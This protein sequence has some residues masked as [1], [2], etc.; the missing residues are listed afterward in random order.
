MLRQ[1]MFAADGEKVGH[2]AGA[3]SQKYMEA[4]SSVMKAA[5]CPEPWMWQMF[6]HPSTSVNAASWSEVKFS[7][8]M[9]TEVTTSQPG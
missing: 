4:Q 6:L 5:C 9:Q 1:P 3:N 8:S 7:H 2:F